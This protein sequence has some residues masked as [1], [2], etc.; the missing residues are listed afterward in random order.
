[1]YLLLTATAKFC[2]TETLNYESWESKKKKNTQI[3]VLESMDRRFKQL[4]LNTNRKE[5][6]AEQSW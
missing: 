4:L 6:V 1:M 2:C 3:K 5:A